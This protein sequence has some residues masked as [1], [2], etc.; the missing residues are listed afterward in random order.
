VAAPDVHARNRTGD[1]DQ[2][3]ISET[4]PVWQMTTQDEYVDRAGPVRPGQPDSAPAVV[5]DTWEE[6]RHEESA[7]AERITQGMQAH[8]SFREAARAPGM[9]QSELST[10]IASN[11]EPL[12]PLNPSAP[13]LRSV[14]I[15]IA[16]TLTRQ[17]R[18][19]ALIEETT[20]VH[21]SI[22][23]IEV[24]AVHEAPAP[25]RRPEPQAN[26]PMSLDDYLARRQGGGT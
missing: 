5:A 6:F 25:R 20:E 12:L 7:A 15:P 18:A 21:V 24:S 4:F 13:A 14:G 9:R 1:P 19:G 22:G 11:P 26:K 2:E 23:R 17:D 3:G 8:S 16:P 10:G